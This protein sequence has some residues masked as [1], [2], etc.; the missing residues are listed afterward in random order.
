MDVAVVRFVD[1][2]IASV[3]AVDFENPWKRYTYAEIMELLLEIRSVGSGEK[4]I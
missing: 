2:K 1:T 3:I 4:K